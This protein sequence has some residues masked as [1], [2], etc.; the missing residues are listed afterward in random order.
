[1]RF[2]KIKSYAK[3]N[4]ALNVL[5]KSSKLHKIESLV[6]FINVYD[7]CLWD[8][9]CKQTFCDSAHTCQQLSSPSTRVQGTKKEHGKAL[10]VANNARVARSLF[11]LLTAVMPDVSSPRVFC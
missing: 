4:L 7:L 8:R 2:K 5:G 11:L 3:I 1:M 10:L 9:Y 6:A